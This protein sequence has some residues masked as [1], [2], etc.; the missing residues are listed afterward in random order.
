[1]SASLA[2]FTPAAALR[3]PRAAPRRAVSSAVRAEAPRDPETSRRAPTLDGR[4]AV[5]GAA[6]SAAM[7]FALAWNCA[8]RA[9]SSGASMQVASLARFAENPSDAI[10]IPSLCALSGFT[11]SPD[12]FRGWGA[13]NSGIRS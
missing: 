12:L 6:V 8:A 2:A 4:R 7:S 1:M 11:P 10:F 3:A 13:T 9:L 5:L